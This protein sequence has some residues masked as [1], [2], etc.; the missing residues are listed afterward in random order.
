MHRIDPM[1]RKRATAILVNFRH[2]LLKL[3]KKFSCGQ[4]S[5]GKK[6]AHHSRNFKKVHFKTMGSSSRCGLAWLIL[7]YM[8]VDVIAM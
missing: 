8:Q 3:E 2:L 1:D 7:L 4:P 5:E 6:I